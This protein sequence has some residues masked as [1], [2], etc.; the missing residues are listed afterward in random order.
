MLEIKNMSVSYQNTLVLDGINLAFQPKTITG[1]IGP[2]GAGKSTLLKAMLG[3]VDYQG[4]AL[5]DHEPLQ[6]Q[7]DT[8]AYVEQRSH[9]DMDFPITVRECVSLGLYPRLQR[10]CRV[11]KSQW[12]KVD[13][14]LALLNLSDYAQRQISQLSGGQFQRML[15]ARCLVQDADYIFLD[16]PFV[17]IDVL[18]EEIIVNLLKQLRQQGKTIVIVHHDLTKARD[19]FDH[20]LLLNK[21]VVDFGSF[22]DVFTK[23]NLY[24][25]YGAL[26]SFEEVV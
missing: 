14:A 6:K 3:L 25:A 11:T 4:Q 24:Q 5:L 26:V 7:L 21:T 8:I 20:I 17:G 23:Q 13:D 18:S 10:F 16:E 19:Y 22:K 15:I 9:V 12:Q 2:N 1:I